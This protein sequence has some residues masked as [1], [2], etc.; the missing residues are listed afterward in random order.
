VTAACPICQKPLVYAD[1]AERKRLMPFCS[2]RC[3]LIDLGEWMSE[4]Y[5]VASSQRVEDIEGAD[6]RED[7][8]S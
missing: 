5:R 4:K 2:A 8:E 6:P 3:K 7:D 1:D